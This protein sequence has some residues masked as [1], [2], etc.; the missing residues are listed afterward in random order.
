M[1][2]RNS[3]TIILFAASKRV[4]A[5]GAA[6]ETVA[7]GDPDGDGNHDIVMANDEDDSISFLLSDGEGTFASKVYYSVSDTPRVVTTS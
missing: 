4:Y 3:R 6:P 5:V 7:L 2:H 1:G